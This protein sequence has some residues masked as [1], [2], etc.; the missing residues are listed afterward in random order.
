MHRCSTIM[1]RGPLKDMRPSIGTNSL[2]KPSSN[3]HFLTAL[4]PV[5]QSNLVDFDLLLFVLYFGI[6]S[7]VA[8]ANLLPH[9]IMTSKL[10]LKHTHTQKDF[11]Q[12]LIHS[13]FDSMKVTFSLPA[14]KNTTATNSDIH[15]NTHTHTMANILAMQFSFSLERKAPLS[16][17]WIRHRVTQ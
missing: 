3:P 8:I 5:Y 13:Q 10:I 9:K 12:N 14:K 15:T 7:I 1:K 4:S 2:K 11:E 6:I 17:P 16:L